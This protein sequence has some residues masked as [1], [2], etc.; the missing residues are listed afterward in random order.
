VIVQFVDAQGRPIVDATVSV[1]ES[2]QPIPDLGMLT[3]DA[4]EINIDVT[5]AGTY[6]FSL[7]HNGQTHRA[8]STIHLSDTKVRLR[9]S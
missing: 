7:Y 8:T 2:P 9:V 4:G 5:A 6:G 3:D 1:I